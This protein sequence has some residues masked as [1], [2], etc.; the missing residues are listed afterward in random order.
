MWKYK[1]NYVD[2][3]IT[4]WEQ[5]LLTKISQDLKLHLDLP[6]V[7]WNLHLSDDGVFKSG[8]R[9]LELKNDHDFVYVFLKFIR[10]GQSLVCHPKDGSDG[11]G[12]AFSYHLVALVVSEMFV[13]DTTSCKEHIYDKLIQQLYVAGRSDFLHL[14]PTSEERIPFLHPRKLR[15]H[16]HG[17]DRV[18]F[19]NSLPTE[20]LY[21]MGY[22]SVPLFPMRDDY[23]RVKK[24]SIMA[25]K[26]DRTMALLF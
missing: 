3:S 21:K 19:Y 17:K 22:F 1:L 20:K 25:S 4:Q 14:N 24:T 2:T 5:Y 26:L 7:W 23:E 13:W 11:A 10:S 16:R 9:V 15:I 12:D 6:G 8:D 18:E